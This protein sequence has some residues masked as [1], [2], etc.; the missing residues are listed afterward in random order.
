MKVKL[1]AQ[2]L[3]SSVANAIEFLAENMKMKVFEGSGPTVRFLRIFNNVFD[4][5]N[6]RNLSGRGFKAPLTVENNAT[7]EP[8]LDTAS[9]YIHS[10]KTLEGRPLFETQKKT[11][12]VGFLTSIQS[13]KG[14]FKEL[15]E[16]ENSPMKFLLTYKV[17]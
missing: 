9:L 8:Y 6:T 12:V 11:F 4:I 13:T 10:L 17:Y 16:K 14:I 7:W 5:L 1:A 2:T 3:S 15:I